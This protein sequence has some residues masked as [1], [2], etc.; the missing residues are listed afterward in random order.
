MAESP[1]FITVGRLGKTRGVK[2]EIY[3]T[4]LTDFPER[5]VDQKEI[6]ID[7]RGQWVKYKI[8]SAR[9]VSGRPVL[10]IEGLDSPEDAARFTNRQLAVPRNQLVELPEGSF[11]IFELMGC[12][13]YD[14]ENGELIG[15]LVEVQQL[16][17]NDVYVIKKKDG[18][19]VLMPAIRRLVEE[20]DIENKKITID[21]AGLFENS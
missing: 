5:F 18:G 2:G 8:E 1:E 12:S 20:V 6:F 16:P 17:A 3:V 21:K 19:E 10:K 4:P 9:L 13:V 14:A 11:Y 15:E 7:H